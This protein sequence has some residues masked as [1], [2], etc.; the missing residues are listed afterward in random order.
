MRPSQQVLA[1]QAGLAMKGLESYR[2]TPGVWDEQL[3]WK[4]VAIIS[5]VF[6]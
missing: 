1:E 4:S 5:G 3:R 2:P 6:Q